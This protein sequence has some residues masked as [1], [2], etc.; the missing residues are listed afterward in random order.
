L[1]QKVYLVGSIQVS[2]RCL[3]IWVMEKLYYYLIH[4]VNKYLYYFLI[5]TS[6]VAI[7]SI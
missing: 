5:L 2:H 7:N 1:L 6:V 3:H 4:I